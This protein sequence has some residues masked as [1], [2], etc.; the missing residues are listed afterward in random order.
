MRKIL[1]LVLNITLL[2]FV[3]ACKETQTDTKPSGNRDLVTYLQNV[4][5]PKNLSISFDAAKVKSVALAKT[6]TADFLE[7]DP[8][9]VAKGLLRREIIDKKPQ[10]VGPWF[11]TG[12]ES[13]T[14]YL[15]VLD[16]GKSFGVENEVNGGLYYGVYINGKPDEDLSSVISGEV[17]P[18]SVNE[19]LQ[20]SLSRSD[21]ASFADLSFVKYADALAAIEKQFDAIG[22][23]KLEVAETYSMDL[24]TIR[25]HYALYIEENRNQEDPEDFSWSKDDEGYLFHLRQL[26]DNIPVINVSWELG[27]GTATGADGN[28]MKFPIIDVTY[29]KDG[30]TDIRA[31]GLYDV[32][33]AK[34]GDEKPLIGVADALQVVFDEYKELLLDE[35]TRVTSAELVYVSIPAKD[36]NELIPAWVF[37]IAKP[38]KWKDAESGAEFPYDDYSQYVVNAIT[39]EKL[40]GMR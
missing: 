28:L 34:G 39:G 23:P 21:Y 6:Y 1:I 14:E 20:R 19:Q 18:P 5:L 25:N 36:T 9:M 15:T 35:G 26:I 7:L 37:G 29:T 16:G 13:L 3:S 2:M 33:A 11:Q 22:L 32:E 38:N 30:V 27:K 12:D 4:K 40:S 8:D 31:S 17:G 10:A 24:E